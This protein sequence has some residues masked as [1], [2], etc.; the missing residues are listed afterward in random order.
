MAVHSLLVVPVLSVV[1]WRPPEPA[2]QAVQDALNRIIASESG[3]SF[4][5]PASSVYFNDAAFNVTG[6]HRVTIVGTNKTT[7]FFAPGVGMSKA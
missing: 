7:L 5:L 6:A 3:G 2:A 4:T 1:A